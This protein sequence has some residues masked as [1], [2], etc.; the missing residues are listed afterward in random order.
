MT[1][2]D[3]QHD[4]PTSAND[5]PPDDVRH[6]GHAGA[7]L[8]HHTI[9]GLLV[10]GALALGVWA[11][12]TPPDFSAGRAAHQAH[13]AASPL[14]QTART[15]SRRLRIDTA[16]R[17]Y[18]LKEKSPPPSLRTLVERGLLRHTDLYYPPTGTEWNYSVNRDDFTLAGPTDRIGSE[19]NN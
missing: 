15:D 12:L 17:L 1:S 11:I 18:S 6:G 5:R 14:L 4:E 10:T 9:T 7:A 3:P 19:T 13:S 2:A 16:A 8:V